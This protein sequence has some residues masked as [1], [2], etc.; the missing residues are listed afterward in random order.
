LTKDKG[1]I[2]ATEVYGQRVA[3][4]RNGR[5]WYDEVVNLD[6][7]GMKFV[8]VIDAGDNSFWAGERP[9]SYILHH[10]VPIKDD[11]DYDKK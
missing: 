6:D 1:F 9:G 8:R 7:V 2:P 3:V 4:M 11:A 10:N 5:T